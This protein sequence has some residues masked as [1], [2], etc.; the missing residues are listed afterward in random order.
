MSKTRMNTSKRVKQHRKRVNR[1]LN[2]QRAEAKLNVCDDSGI[3]WLAVN[4]AWLTESTLLEQ[5]EYDEYKL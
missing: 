1:E 4:T 2:T 5:E 3:D